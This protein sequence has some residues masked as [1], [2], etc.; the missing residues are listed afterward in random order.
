LN[1]IHSEVVRLKHLVDE[2]LELRRLETGRINLKMS[3]FDLAKLAEDV[4][5]KMRAVLSTKG[6]QKAIDIQ[7]KAWHEQRLEYRAEVLQG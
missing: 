3:K 5:S 4:A 6:N 2:L 1:S 7:V